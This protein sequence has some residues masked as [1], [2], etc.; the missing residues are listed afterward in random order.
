MCENFNLKNLNKKIE[1]FNVSKDDVNKDE[2]PL[3]LVEV[4]RKGNLIL[5]EYEDNDNSAI[6]ENVINE[7]FP[8]FETKFGK[9]YII[10]K[11]GDFFY[12]E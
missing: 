6:S 1:E 2:M 8:E 7:L 12:Q 9:N 11:D 4:Y 3:E 10:E 5:Y